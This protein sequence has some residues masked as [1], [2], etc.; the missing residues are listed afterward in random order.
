MKSST[1][2]EV[3]PQF[4]QEVISQ[5]DPFQQ[6]FQTQVIISP[7][8]VKRKSEDEFRYYENVFDETHNVNDLMPYPGN[9]GCYQTYREF[10]TWGG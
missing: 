2:P 6:P 3:E 5:I 10:H 4:E 8:S 9:P 7:R 1:I